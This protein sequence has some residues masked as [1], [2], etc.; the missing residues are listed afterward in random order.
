MWK[1]DLMQKKLHNSGEAAWVRPLTKMEAA[2][3]GLQIEEA[4][5]DLLSVLCVLLLYE[6]FHT[7]INLS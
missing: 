6:F 1:N 4:V 3:N 7:I 5:L 2:K